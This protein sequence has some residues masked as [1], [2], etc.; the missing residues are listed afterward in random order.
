MGASAEMDTRTMQANQ[1]GHPQTRLRGQR[2]QGTVAL[3][4]RA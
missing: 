2:Q 1:F 4:G 3:P